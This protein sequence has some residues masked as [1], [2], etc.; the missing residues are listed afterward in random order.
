VINR[1]SLKVG[2]NGQLLPFETIKGINLIQVELKG[3]GIR[4]IKFPVQEKLTELEWWY[5]IIKYSDHFDGKEIERC[6]GLGLPERLEQVLRQLEYVGL[7]PKKREEYVTEVK[8]IDTYDDELKRIA[9]ESEQKGELK[10]KLEGELKGKLESLLDGFIDFDFQKIPT[11]AAKR[12]KDTEKLLPRNLVE[13]V[14]GNYINEGKIIQKQLE[15]FVKLLEENEI[16][17]D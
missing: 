17:A 13:E 1:S 9:L 10:G 12:I 5:Y 4:D 2:E 14:G 11:T 6:K 15:D 7:D 16:L 8:E 3:E